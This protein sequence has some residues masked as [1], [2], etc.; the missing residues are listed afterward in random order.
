MLLTTL[1]FHGKLYHVNAFNLDSPKPL[2]GE[3]AANEVKYNNILCI[4]YKSHFRAPLLHNLLHLN[5]M[6]IYV[7]TV[8]AI[9]GIQVNEVN[10]PA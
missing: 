2:V 9:S 7:W 4:C 8:Y 1:L 10:A 3:Q 6:S 5:H